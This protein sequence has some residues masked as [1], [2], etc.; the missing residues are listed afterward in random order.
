MDTLFSRQYGTTSSSSW[1]STLD[2]N[3]ATICTSMKAKGIVIYATGFNLS[4]SSADTLVKNRLKACASPGTAY[5]SDSAN[6]VDL[7]A[8]FNHI[9][10]DVLNKSIYVSK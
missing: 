10:E 1:N 8:F 6:G 5:Y 9:G 7:Q 3:L 4:N 2:T